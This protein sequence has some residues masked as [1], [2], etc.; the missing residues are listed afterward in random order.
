[1]KILLSGMFLVLGNGNWKEYICV[2]YFYKPQVQ[3]SKEMASTLSATPPTSCFYMPASYVIGKWETLTPQHLAVQWKVTMRLVSGDSF[4]T[5]VFLQTETPCQD[6]EFTLLPTG[7]GKLC[8]IELVNL[9]NDERGIYCHI[10]VILSRKNMFPAGIIVSISIQWEWDTEDAYLLFFKPIQWNK[11]SK[12][13][14]WKQ[15]ILILRCIINPTEW[16]LFTILVYA[17]V[18]QGVNIKQ[19]LLENIYN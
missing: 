14:Q 3:K 2:L 11:L 18:Y 9:C 1:M 13:V 10:M 15:I 4:V 8:W 19:P 5:G 6:A 17:F 7:K 16:Y 12:I